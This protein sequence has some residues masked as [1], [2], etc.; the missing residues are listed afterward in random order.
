MAEEQEKVVTV[1]VN[2]P[3][4][5]RVSITPD[6]DAQLW[7]T[8]WEQGDTLGGWSVGGES[9]AQFD[10]ATEVAENGE[11]AIF[12][13]EVE[14][15]CELVLIYPYES[16]SQVTSAGHYPI[17]LARQTVDLA[18]P[19]NS[20]A[21]SKLYMVSDPVAI[22]T[23][24]VA[25]QPT[26]MRHMLA[27]LEI[28][29]TPAENIDKSSYEY[30]LYQIEV[31]CTN[32]YTSSSLDLF[33]TGYI[34]IAAEG[35]AQFCGSTNGSVVVDIE[36]SPL[37]KYDEE[38]VIPMVIAPATLVKQSY[39]T[40]YLDLTFRVYRT[41]IFTGRSYLDECKCR[42]GF[43]SNV[44]FVRGTYNIITA[45]AGGTLGTGFSNEDT[46]SLEVNLN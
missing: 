8:S 45:A 24:G 32:D 12:S 10:M 42:K 1:W 41:N 31:E 11:S 46:P 44:E 5:S 17:D 22:S 39:I 19:Y 38:V 14:S 6:S 43:T 21:A 35:G 27:T 4:Q 29:F 3:S 25:Q 34:D 18:D 30:T 2:Q 13:G 16:A 28:H 7:S 9:I 36:N 26:D 15:D 40:C 23:D 33:D 20:M 37:L